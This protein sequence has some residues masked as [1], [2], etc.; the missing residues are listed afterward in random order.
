MD[1]I[2][3]DTTG[4][5]IEFSLGEAHT[6]N[7]VDLSAHWADSGT[8]FTEGSTEAQSNGTTP[9]TLVAA[10]AASTR[11][12]VKT[13]TVHNNDTV[14]HTFI[15][16]INV[17]ATLYFIYKSSLAAGVSWS[18][19]NSDLTNA[20]TLAGITPGAGGLSILD[21]ASTSAIRTTLGLVIGTNVQAWDT[22]LDTWATKTPPSGTV[23]GTT[24]SQVLT[25]KTLLDAT[26][27]VEELT[28][29]A[30][31]ASITPTGGSLR[32]YLKVTAL[33][34]GTTINAPSGSPADGNMLLMRIKDNGTARALGYNAIFRDVGVTR[35]TTTTISKT[36]YQLARY[37]SADTKWD[38]ISVTQEA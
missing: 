1:V 18:S 31:N 25:N 13:I 26:N 27:V 37:N 4:K 14:T 11:R 29:V 36:L 17:S 34:E 6:T 16:K 7:P 19:N 38:I 28:S 24:D 33:A 2:I 22:D 32:N 3:L 30:S 10:P 35:K 23:L 20:Q 9:V 15:L 12:L 21:D 8:S 5:S